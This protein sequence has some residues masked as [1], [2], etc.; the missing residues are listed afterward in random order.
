MGAGGAPAGLA[1]SVVSFAPNLPALWQTLAS[2][3]LAVTVARREGLLRRCR[4][5]LVDNGPGPGWAERLRP[6]LARFVALAPGCEARLITGHGNLGFGRGHNL[7]PRPGDTFRLVLNPDVILA[8]NAIRE[9][10]LFMASHPE[11]GLLSP[12]AEDRE[13]GRQYLCKNYPALF[14]LFLRG[15]A[16]ARVRGWFAVRLAAYE[17]REGCGSEEPGFDA[18]IASGCFLFCRSELWE[19]LGGFD[20][21]YFMYFEDFDFSLRAGRMTK[22]AYVPKVRIVHAGGHAARKGLRHIVMFARSG[23]RF[24]NRHGWRLW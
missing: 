23:W 22:L 14:D 21:G 2:L 16:P 18:P 15:L 7:A 12:Y 24:F 11:V 19:A 10:L 13:G 8:R 20:E 3:A 5:F 6:L 4:L 9:A 17:R 1:V